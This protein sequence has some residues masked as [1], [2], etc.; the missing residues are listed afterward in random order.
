MSRFR[1]KKRLAVKNTDFVR[2]VQPPGSILQSMVLKG[3]CNA[4]TSSICFSVVNVQTDFHAT[5][6]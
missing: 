4:S 3:M 1:T 6:I 5:V 2:N